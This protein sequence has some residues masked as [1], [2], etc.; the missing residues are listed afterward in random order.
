[1]SFLILFDGYLTEMFAA[2][3]LIT[4]VYMCLDIVHNSN[5]VCILNRRRICNLVYYALHNVLAYLIS[6]NPKMIL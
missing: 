6:E 3:A 5:D 1:M 2:D 4:F